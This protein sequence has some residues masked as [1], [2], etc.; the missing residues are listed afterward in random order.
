MKNIKFYLLIFIFV[1][2]L[3]GC[4]FP[5]PKPKSKSASTPAPKTSETTAVYYDFEDVLVPSEM[6]IVDDKTM[7]IS[8]PDFASGVI[9]LQGRVEKNSLFSFFTN[10]MMKDNWKIESSIK[11]PGVTIL[12]FN[13]SSRCAVITFQDSQFNNTIV[14][15]GVA[16]ILGSGY[17]N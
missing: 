15:I 11:S 7:V 17:N 12:V 10:N 2:I 16:P 4:V 14:Q 1:F 5:T 13:K 3:A 6:S 9:T 8:T